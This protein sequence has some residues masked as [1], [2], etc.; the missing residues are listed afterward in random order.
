MIDCT[1]THKHKEIDHRVIA[2]SDNA[3]VIGKID[4]TINHPP[5]V[6]TRRVNK[7]IL[8][9]LV[10]KTEIRKQSK[11]G[12]NH[13]DNDKPR[14]TVIPKPGKSSEEYRV[15]RPILLLNIDLKIYTKILATRLNKVH[16]QLVYLDQL[17]FY[18]RMKGE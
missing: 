14:I 3:P 18:K 11:E 4:C 6:R 16:P 12:H 8:R 10:V 1:L 13:S 9:D 5:T 2:L 15:Y 17:G 7:P